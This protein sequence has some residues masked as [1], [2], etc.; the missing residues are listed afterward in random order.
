MIVDLPATTVDKL[1]TK[2]RSLRDD[3]GAMALSR[4][5]TLVIV[6][7]EA[8]AEQALSVATKSTHQHPSRIVCVVTSTRRAN[9]RLDGELRVGGD[10]GASEIVVLRLFGDLTKHAESVVLPFLLPDSPVVAWWPY[11]APADPAADPVGALAQRRI[12]DAEHAPDPSQAVA[13]RARVYAQGDTDLVWTRTTRWRGILAA[14]LEQP[15]F[16]EVTHVSV[17]GGLDSGSTDLLAAWLAYKLGCSVTRGRAPIGAGLL[18][19]R[20]QRASGPIDLV[21]PDGLAAILAHPGQP[22][23]RLALARRQ[24]DECL[25]DELARL[26]PDEVYEETLREGLP[27]LSGQ[28]LMAVT[29]AVE[30]GLAPSLEDARRMASSIRRA[31]AAQEGAA[32]VEKPQPPATAES[33]VVHARAKARAEEIRQER[34]LGAAASGLRDS[35]DGTDL[36]DAPAGTR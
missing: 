25:A 5:L 16:E 26:D 35:E 17:C 1:G 8:H 19:V 11:D 18:S 7:D 4:V 20:L 24:D 23:R 12:T 3:V 33:S 29:A 6:V 2:L 36:P 21:R 27:L 10:A 34:A 30:K 9:S 22:V 15:P 28:S 13:A 31:T 32:M 14:A